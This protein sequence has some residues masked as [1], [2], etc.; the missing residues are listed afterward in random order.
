MGAD[1]VADKRDLG[2]FVVVVWGS[3]RWWGVT[4]IFITPDLIIIVS[5]DYVNASTSGFLK[6]IWSIN[7]RDKYYNCGQMGSVGSANVLVEC[8]S[9][10]AI[11]RMRS[12]RVS[13][14]GIFLFWRN[15]KK[16]DERTS[17]AARNNNNST[18]AVYRSPCTKCISDSQ[19]QLEARPSD[20]AINLCL[21]WK[22]LT[23]FSASID[24]PWLWN[25]SLAL[26]VCGELAA[27]TFNGF[28][29]TKLSWT[30]AQ[31]VITVPYSQ[32][33]DIPM[34]CTKAQK[35]WEYIRGYHAYLN[36]SSFSSF[37]IHSPPH[38]FALI[39]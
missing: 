11:L 9:F 36:F 27:R 12:T 3:P 7:L 29:L 38:S 15:N 24:D 37:E 19:L 34:Q 18:K 31:A 4:A 10:T 22:S 13:V 33:N 8:G 17:F 16:Q 5:V 1:S 39:S 21:L 26:N 2:W 20:H 30:S 6:D 14:L 23:L 35:L 25:I 28:K 32:S